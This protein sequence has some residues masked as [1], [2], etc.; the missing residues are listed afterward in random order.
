MIL[1]KKYTSVLQFYARNQCINIMQQEYTREKPVILC[2]LLFV[3]EER[4][5]LIILQI[6]IINPLL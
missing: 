2:Y 1:S 5:C 3:N 6:I 4:E